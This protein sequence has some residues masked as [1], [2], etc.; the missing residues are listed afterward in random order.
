MNRT[1]TVYFKYDTYEITFCREVIK[2]VIK[3]CG[4]SELPRGVMSEALPDVVQ[5]LII[6]KM[7]NVDSRIE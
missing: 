4:E 5:N 1:I 7:T 3:F 2:H 6:R